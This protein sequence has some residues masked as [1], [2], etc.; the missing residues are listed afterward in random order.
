[1]PREYDVIGIGNALV[2]FLIELDDEKICY[3]NLK[4]GNFHMVSAEESRKIIDYLKD[5]EIKI[6]PGGSC[7]N[8]ISTIAKLGGKTIFIGKVGDDEHGDY[9]CQELEKDNVKIN[10]SKGPGMTG[11]AITM[12]TPDTER[13]FSVHLGESINIKKHDI[14]EEDIIKS[15]VFHVEGYQLDDEDLK[16]TVLHAMDIAKKNGV[17]ISM[18]LGDPG[19]IQR[20]LKDFKSIVTLYT[21]ILFLNEE[22]AKVFTGLQD[23]DIAIEK[24]SMI[25]DIV[26]VKL[27]KK[28]SLIKKGDK[29]IQ[30]EPKIVNAVDTTGA[31]DNYAAGFLYGITKGLG[32]EKSGKI[33][34]IISAEIVKKVGARFDVDPKGLIKDITNP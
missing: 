20:N 26:V 7:A 1:M 19:L 32:L 34:N 8:T 23:I 13:T 12:I 4:K 28:G 25:S 21:N 14:I 3:L 16:Q 33:A 18:D 9:F 30:I 17:I 27:G 22:E 15:K 10:I 6:A 31:G 29:I 2:D 11:R 24:A 5:H